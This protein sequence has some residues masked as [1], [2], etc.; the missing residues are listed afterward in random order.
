MSHAAFE[1]KILAKASTAH[2]L[3]SALILFTDRF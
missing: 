2:M 3:A 1:A